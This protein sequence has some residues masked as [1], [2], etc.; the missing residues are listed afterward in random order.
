MTCRKS[1][2]DRPTFLPEIGPAQI[3]RNFIR[4]LQIQQSR[5]I[6]PQKHASTCL[7]NKIRMHCRPSYPVATRSV[8]EAFVAKLAIA[9]CGTKHTQ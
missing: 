3:K 4:L 2:I 1:E 7:L 6:T 8:F 5:V 9:F